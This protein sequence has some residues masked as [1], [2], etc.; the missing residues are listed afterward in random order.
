MIYFALDYHSS[1]IALGGACSDAAICGAN[2]P[3]AMIEAYSH[4]DMGVTMSWA[5]YLSST[6]NDTNSI[7]A[8]KWHSSGSYIASVA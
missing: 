6:T 5:K 8:V 4:G 7:Q 2:T 1:G 3:N